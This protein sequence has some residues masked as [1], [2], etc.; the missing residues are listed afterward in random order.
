ML[1]VPSSVSEARRAVDD[2]YLWPVERQDMREAA[3]I[4]QR[5][6]EDIHEAV[7][8]GGEDAVVTVQNLWRKGWSFTQIEAHATVAFAVYKAEHGTRRTRR[9][10][11]RRD[12]VSAIATDAAALTLFIMPVLYWADILTG[13][14]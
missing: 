13:L 11:G 8:A 14:L 5:M 12:S 9:T 3:H 1:P 4:R 10:L 7:H 2:G 6:G